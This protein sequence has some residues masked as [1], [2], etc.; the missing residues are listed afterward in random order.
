MNPESLEDAIVAQLADLLAD[1]IEVEHLPDVPADLSKPFQNARVTVAYVGSEFDQSVTRGIPSNF[2]ADYAV[3]EEFAQVEVIIRARKLR[4]ANGIHQ[5]SKKVKNLLFGYKPPHF[6]EMFIKTYSQ[7][8]MDSLEGIWM[9]SFIFIAKTMVVPV[10]IEE[11]LPNLSQVDF[12]LNS[13]LH[14]LT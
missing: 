11:E 10:L 2:A 4:G 14:G 8:P 7:V 13:E 3:Q 12:N 5:I 9:Y 1:D 6:H